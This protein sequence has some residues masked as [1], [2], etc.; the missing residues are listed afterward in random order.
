MR[1]TILTL[2]LIGF[3]LA[4]ARS[5]YQVVQKS[6]FHDTAWLGLSGRIVGG[7]HLTTDG[8]NLY[9]G[10]RRG[11]VYALSSDLKML[12]KKDLGGN[13][14]STPAAA[15]GILVVG[16]S[17]GKIVALDTKTGKEVWSADV[18]G[19]ILGELALMPENLLL[20]GANDGYLYAFNSKNGELKWRYKRD[21]PDRITIH[22][23]ARPTSEGHIIY[24][25][26]SDGTISALRDEDGKEMWS[27]KLS[28]KG[29]FADLVGG[30]LVASTQVLAAQF[31]GDLYSLNPQGTE[32]WNLPGAGSAAKAVSYEKSILAPAGEGEIKRVDAASGASVW[33]YKASEPSHW[34][35]M[36]TDGANLLVTSFEGRIHVLDLK[37]G[38]LLWRYDVGASITG[39]PVRV[40]NK[41]FLLTQKGAIFSVSSR[42]QSK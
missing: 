15:Q 8:Q 23:F 18:T 11:H 38:E 42:S 32:R 1:Q 20:A 22:S 16:T 2:L 24:A 33:S 12:W 30:V 21:L 40:D 29:R 17:E 10:S 28:S 13:I 3:S 36:I 27:R 19:E 14:D 35:G 41:I 4:C 31:D 25:A 37:T 26:F 39:A 5:P 9:F 7:S 34:S 6:R